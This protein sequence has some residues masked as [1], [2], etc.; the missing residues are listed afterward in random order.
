MLRLLA[1]LSLNKYLLNSNQEVVWAA[2][3]GGP[4]HCW[5][6]GRQSV[7]KDSP[8]LGRVAP[9]RILF[10]TGTQSSRCRLP[11][12]RKEALCHHHGPFS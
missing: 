10:S 2:H 4:N 12:E 7:F 8:T 11:S 3:A 6:P 5:E 1:I 9:G